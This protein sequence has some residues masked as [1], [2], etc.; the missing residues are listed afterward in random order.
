[1]SSKKPTK[2]KSTGFKAERKCA[3]RGWYQCHSCNTFKPSHEYKDDLKWT[4][5]NR[6]RCRECRR[7]TRTYSTTAHDTAKA[8]VRKYGPNIQE[9]KAAIEESMSRAIGAMSRSYQDQPAV[10]TPVESRVA[11]TML[12]TD[13]P[14]VGGSPG[15]HSVNA[16]LS[17][18]K[19]PKCRL[20]LPSV[21]YD[22][23]EDVVC[24]NCRGAATAV[25]AQQE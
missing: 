20:K 24:L 1:M 7:Q 2:G 8:Y 16:H 21:F 19:C 17:Y 13:Q 18:R 5:P 22:R 14:A 9:A 15:M 6:Y 4:N 12:R 11:G 25:D 3:V 10:S 23:D